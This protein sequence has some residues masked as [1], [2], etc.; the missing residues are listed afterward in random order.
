MKVTTFKK[1][2]VFCKNMHKKEGKGDNIRAST[3]F[4]SSQVTAASGGP[5]F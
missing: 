3:L 2:E 4:E 5:E 1:H